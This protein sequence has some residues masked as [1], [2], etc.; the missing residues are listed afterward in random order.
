LVHRNREGM[1]ARLRL[2]ALESGF[3]LLVSVITAAGLAAVLFLGTR[4][5]QAGVLTLGELL[6]VMVYLA[7]LYAPLKTLTNKGVSMESSLASAERAFA[8]PDQRDA[9]AGHGAFGTVQW[10]GVGPL[11][12]VLRQRCREHRLRPPRCRRGGGRRRGEGGQR[13]RLHRRPSRGL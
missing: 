6:L 12:P 4:H 7:Q 9:A 2:L 10:P 8:L 13:P 5:V 1:R 11:G 3:G